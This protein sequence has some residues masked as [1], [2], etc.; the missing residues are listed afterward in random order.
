M[1]FFINER[2]HAIKTPGH[3]YAL[4]QPRVI[5][6]SSGGRGVSATRSC[7]TSVWWCSSVRALE[8]GIEHLTPLQQ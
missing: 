6:N 3:E 8:E 2:L 4:Q 5:W 1:P 7:P